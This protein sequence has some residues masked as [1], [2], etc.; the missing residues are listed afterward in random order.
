[1]IEISKEDLSDEELE[2]IISS[3]GFQKMLL[4]QRLADGIRVLQTHDKLYESMVQAIAR[5][6]SEL[7]SDE[8]VREVLTLL[9]Y[10]VS[11]YTEPLTTSEEDKPQLP[12]K[13]K[14]DP[15]GPISD[16]ELQETK[17]EE[18]LR[19]YLEDRLA[20]TDELEIKASSIASDTDLSSYNIGGILGQWRHAD[21]P[22][23]A[24]T[25]IEKTGSGNIW[26]IKRMSES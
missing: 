20:E 23:F 8:A 13:V 19:E 14:P 10:E 15:D 12:K 7:D 6:H 5:R 11:M 16:P 25:A 1:M 18:A 26:N 4:Y 24:I 2:T 22:P 9:E 21:D 3:R 17:S